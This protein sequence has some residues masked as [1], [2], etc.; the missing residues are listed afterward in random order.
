VIG[1]QLLDVALSCLDVRNDI[2]HLEVEFNALSRES[3]SENCQGLTQHED[4]AGA[5]MLG[6]DRQHAKRR[7]K[8]QKLPRAVPCEIQLRSS[9]AQR[10]AL[11]Q[12]YG[13]FRI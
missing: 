13:G 11:T 3:V 1:R 9:S 7:L 12:K 5:R 8:P 10:A 6:I 2:T 4:E